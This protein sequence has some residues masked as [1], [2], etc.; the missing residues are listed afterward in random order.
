MDRTIDTKTDSTDICEVCGVPIPNAVFTDRH[1]LFGVGT[2]RQTK[3]TDCA[4][5]A[6]FRTRT[7][8]SRPYRE[9]GL[10]PKPD[11]H[12]PDVYVKAFEEA[13]ARRLK[14]A[15]EMNS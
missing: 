5:L 14:A 2:C 15:E 8:K 12:A 4:F 1:V 9:P 13:K 10:R 3:C 7:T 6:E 11:G